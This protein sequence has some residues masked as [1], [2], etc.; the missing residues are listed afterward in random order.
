MELVAAIGA[1]WKLAQF[2]RVHGE[3]FH[4][5]FRICSQKASLFEAEVS[6]LAAEGPADNHMI[7]HVDLQNPGSFAEPASQPHIGFTGSRVP[8]WMIALCGL[9]SY[10]I[11]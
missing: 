6:W 3:R 2:R 4:D 1:S 10:V 9:D 7:E 5:S 8:R 11:W